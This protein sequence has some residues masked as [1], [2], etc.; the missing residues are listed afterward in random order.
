MP[1]TTEHH[2]KEPPSST[3]SAYNTAMST[4][5]WRHSP[6]NHSVLQSN[7]RVLRWSDGSLTFQLATNP[8]LQYECD[9]HPLAPR[10]RNPRKPTP[11]S[12]QDR[13][14]R[15]NMAGTHYNPN[16]DSFTYLASP[17]SSASVMRITNKIT[18]GLTLHPSADTADDA[19]ERLQNSL[20]AAVRGKNLNPDGG[21]SLL[22][23]NEDPELAQKKAEVAEKEKVKAQRRREALET[24]E[25]D[26]ANRVLGRSGQRAGG[27]TV[28]TLEDDELGMGTSGGR[29]RGSRPKPRRQRRDDYSDDEGYGR[30]KTKEDEYDEED[31]FIARSDE[32]EEVGADDDEED[33][34]ELD[35]DDEG[36][37]KAGKQGRRTKD[38]DSPKRGRKDD[39]A[40][41]EA[42]EDGGQAAARTKRRRVVE[43]DEEDE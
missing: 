22:S 42:T 9:G 30:R 20:A 5:R 24:R 25:R 3:F 27:L 26:R 17:F 19:L 37:E 34:E 11:T 36:R 4:I 29:A 10:Q 28:G 18:A 41:E 39:E 12:V 7:A 8:T 14:S 6:R 1:P 15:A 2:T 35:D 13:K 23:T 16:Q 31:E 32:E 21:I 43:D 33:E 38:K 40:T